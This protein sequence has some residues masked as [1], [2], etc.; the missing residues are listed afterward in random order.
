MST[1]QTWFI[2]GTSTGF[3][4][5][6]AQKAL[7]DGHKVVATCRDVSDIEDLGT[8]YEDR[9]L[10]ARVDVTD[11][12]SIT[13]A[14]NE[15]VSKFGK[16][17]IL[18]NN[19]GF[20]LAGAIEETSEAEFKKLYEVNVFG[21]LRVTKAVLPLM[22]DQKS[23]LII[24]LSSVVGQNAFPFIGAYSSTKFAVEGITEA[25]AGEVEPFGIRTMLIEPGAFDTEF[26]GSMKLAA[27]LL[28]PYQEAREKV[29][30]D[31][32]F[33]GDPVRAAKAIVAAA[34]AS[35]PPIRLALGPDAIET[36]REKAN[37]VLEQ[38]SAWEAVS[39]ATNKDNSEPLGDKIPA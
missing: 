1:Q 36:I 32:E 2:T 19:A 16:I 17:D 5:L 9:I 15:A 26:A 22:R 20:G 30:S 8:D 28:D 37:S 11:E 14:I 23:G 18:M 24:N 39:T 7:E 38:M 31:I 13:T 35:P 29:M 12:S 25:L 3:G 34:T 27:K 4:R 10:R 33:L 6:T 21:L